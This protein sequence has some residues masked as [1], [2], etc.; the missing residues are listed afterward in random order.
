MRRFGYSVFHLCEV[1]IG[2]YSLRIPWPNLTV[3]LHVQLGICR[4]GNSADADR[5]FASC[6]HLD[7][8]V[9]PSSGRSVNQITEE[10]SVVL[11]SR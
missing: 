4:L 6:A 8:G 3:V 9:L 11:S 1:T 2:L 10:T 7:A 5:N